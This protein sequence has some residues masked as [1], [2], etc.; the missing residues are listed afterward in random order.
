MGELHTL[1][2]INCIHV[3]TLTVLGELHTL[4]T[5]VDKLYCTNGSIYTKPGRLQV[6]R[7]NIINNFTFLQ[8][9]STLD[10]RAISYTFSSLF[11]N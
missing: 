11:S 9:H 1:L 10:P 2:W 5:V 8:F 6:G 7:Y 4:Y 3:R